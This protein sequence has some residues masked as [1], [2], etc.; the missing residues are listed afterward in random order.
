MCSFRPWMLPWLL[1]SDASGISYT[2]FISM[3]LLHLSG[4]LVITK[5]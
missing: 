4:Q 1:G 5:A 3:E 2:F